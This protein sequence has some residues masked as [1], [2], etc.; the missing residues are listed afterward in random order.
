[1]SSHSSEARTA[2]SGRTI[3]GNL[4]SHQLFATVYTELRRIAARE[5]RRNGGGMVSPTTLIH[6]TFL[7][8]S[9]RKF[10]DHA[11]FL[12]YAARAMR[13]LII[14]Q[15]RVRGRKKRGGEFEFTSLPPDLT[16]SDDPD[17]SI[18]KLADALDVLAT[19]EPRLAQCIELRFFCGFSLPEIAR[20]WNV[21][22]RTTQRDWDKARVMLY[23]LIK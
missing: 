9:Q 22:E 19:I 13:G 7:S 2:A 10:V 1:V 14:D 11:H 23:Q 4:E 3:E 5:L 16:V 8:L 18:E 15:L 20:M 17:L 21:S 6:E 12:G